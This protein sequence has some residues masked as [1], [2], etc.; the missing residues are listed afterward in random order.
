MATYFITQAGTGTKAQ[1]VDISTPMSVATHN[2]ETWSDGDIIYILDAITSQIS[3]PS[4]ASSGNLITYY[5]DYPGRNATISVTG[6]GI[7]INDS[8]LKFSGITVTSCTIHGI[9]MSADVAAMEG[10]IFE[11]MIITNNAQRGISMLANR[12]GGYTL[13][14]TIL[15]GC[16][17]TGNGTNGIRLTSEVANAL[18]N[19][20]VGMTITDCNISGNDDLNVKIG[21]SGHTNILHTDLIFQD[22]VTSGSLG[23]DADSGGCAIQGWK[24]S[25]G[26]R[27]KCIIYRNICSDNKGVR[28]GINILDCENFQILRNSCND[29]LAENS[30]GADTID[31]N[32]ILIDNGCNDIFC[33][34]NTCS[35]NI[36]NATNSNSG[37]GIMVLGATNTIVTGNSGTGNKHGMYLGEAAAHT[38]TAMSDN[39]FLSCSTSGYYVAN[40]VTD[41]VT[42]IYNN[43][44]TGVN[45]GDTGFSLGTGANQTNEDYNYFYNFAT[46]SS[47]GHTLGS[48]TSTLDPV[49][50]GFVPA[51]TAPVV[52]SGIKWGSGVA[53]G[54]GGE[55]KSSFDRDIGAIQTTYSPFHPKNL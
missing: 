1:A 7:Y 11:S 17:I 27:E 33:Y 9:L 55:P 23:V 35:G 30:V 19:L 20:F 16:T 21:N 38:G 45:S 40:P 29:N 6:S 37:S 39:T 47:V 10:I 13:T 41:S 49:L 15:T 22:N 51:E 18:T 43:I 4:S 28:G 34:D 42:L 36:G 24:S 25:N 32:G 50:T 26:S 8:N 12:V 2:G 54:Y 48:N 46:D 53:E 52:G 31:G 5:G 3:P 44:F 14:N